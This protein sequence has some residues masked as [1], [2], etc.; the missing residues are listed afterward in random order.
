MP[1]SLAEK[2]RVGGMAPINDSPASKCSL[3]GFP[4]LALIAA[5]ATCSEYQRTRRQS[6]PL[7]SATS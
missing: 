3:Q 1:D 2:S 7:S 6:P 5:G 4:V